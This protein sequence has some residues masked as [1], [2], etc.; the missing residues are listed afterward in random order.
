[1]KILIIGGTGTIGKE[2]VK[3]LNK[4]NEVIIVGNSKGEFTVDINSKNSIQKLFENVGLVDTILSVTG[5]GEFGKFDDKSNTGYELSWENKVMGQVNLVR[6]GLDYLKEGGSI[7]LTSGSAATNH[8][9]GTAS[10]SM[11]CA[12]IN[13]FVATAALEISKNRRINVVSPSFVKE[14][15][16]LLG[17]DS[18]TGIKAEDVATYYQASIEDNTNGIVY[19]AHNGKY[20]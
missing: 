12:A 8:N 2:I 10:I 16:E 17:M 13:A 6:I 18:S 9:P 1:M 20:S 19:Q 15:M 14:T 11:A 3:L 7:T 4:E 5:K